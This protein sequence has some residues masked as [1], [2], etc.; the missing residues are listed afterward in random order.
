MP[1]PQRQPRLYHVRIFAPDGE[2]QARTTHVVVLDL[3]PGPAMA[4]AKSELDSLLK[5]LAA[6][7]NPAASATG[8][9]LTVT[10]VEAGETFKWLGH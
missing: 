10:D 9:Y 2:I 5:S 4:R 7:D 6:L 3:T 8:H 1:N